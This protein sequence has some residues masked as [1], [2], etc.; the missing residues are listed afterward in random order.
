MVSTVLASNLLQTFTASTFVGSVPC[1][2]IS[3]A[4]SPTYSFITLNAATRVITVAYS[5]LTSAD[6]G[7][8]LMTV[9]A[10]LVANPSVSQALTFTVYVDPCVVTSASVSLNAMNPLLTTT[11]TILDAVGYQL[12]LTTYTQSPACGYSPTDVSL[13]ANPASNT[14][15]AIYPFFSLFS[16]TVMQVQTS[17][18]F[19][20]DQIFTIQQQTTY[21]TVVVTQTQKVLF[22]Y[23]PGTSWNSNSISNIITSVL[24][25]PS[26]AA[27]TFTASTVTSLTSCGLVSYVLSPSTYSFITLNTALRTLTVVS[28][29]AADVETY[30]LNL[31]AS[32]TSY[33]SVTQ[34]IPFS[35]TI[36]ACVVT[37]ISLTT[38]AGF[39]S[40][41]TTN[42]YVG[43]PAGF[44]ISMA[45]HTQ[46]P[47][48]G[49]ASSFT[50]LADT[51]PT[52]TG[53]SAM[54][55]VIQIDSTTVQIKSNDIGLDS[56]VYS[57]QQTTT[58][59]GLSN[60]QTT[61]VKFVSCLSTTWNPNTVAG[62]TTSVLVSPALAP[63]SFSA[64]TVTFPLPICGT[65][66]YSLSPIS[67]FLILD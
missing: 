64:S 4:L 2:S 26:L 49:Y 59:G 29:S 30:F 5:A 38:C 57:I 43:D 66:S 53:A 52:S 61:N 17:D 23:C 13:T 9:T 6:I 46:S 62:M 67:P 1:S 33:P 39:D 7:S 55:F 19:L 27:Q 51:F 36:N 25:S 40:T 34:T 12:P 21:G 60:I 15:F 63:Q 8:Y 48:C 54:P 47:A 45:T 24:V 11:V 22:A 16:P 42:V 44:L 28:T 41:L 56:L 3:Y 35:V 20:R 32:L 14:G 18:T 37:S 65:V 58:I 31:V 50:I 10:S